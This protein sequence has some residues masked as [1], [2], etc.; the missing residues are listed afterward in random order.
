[1]ENE[2]KRVWGLFHRKDTKWEYDDVDKVAGVVFCAHLF[3]PLFL[4]YIL[5]QIVGPYGKIDLWILLVSH[6]QSYFV[7]A[8]PATILQYQFSDHKVRNKVFFYI[9]S[10]ITVSTLTLY[11]YQ[12]TVEYKERVESYSEED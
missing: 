11:I 3:I 2:K 9:L 4:Y 8:I 5:S 10:I 7:H 1:M 12:D 6:W